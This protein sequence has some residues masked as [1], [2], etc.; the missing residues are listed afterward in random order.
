MTVHALQSIVFEYLQRRLKRASALPPGGDIVGRIDE[1]S[2]LD[3]IRVSWCKS[4]PSTALD[5][6][7]TWPIGY[8]RLPAGQRDLHLRG[9]TRRARA[10][11]H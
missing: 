8:D 7:V 6:P 1:K 10:S 3:R 11:H 5:E 4:A 2:Q 9:P